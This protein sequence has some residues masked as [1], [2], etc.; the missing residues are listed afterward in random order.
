MQDVVA[1]VLVGL[2]LTYL[3]VRFV[4]RKRR[5]TCCGEKVCPATQRM[6]ERIA[7]ETPSDPA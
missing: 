3:F 5:P 2:A 1:L 7:A 6:L 4:V